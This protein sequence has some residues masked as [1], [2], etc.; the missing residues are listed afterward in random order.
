[1]LPLVDFYVMYKALSS[2]SMAIAC[3][4]EFLLVGEFL[5]QER[6][7]E[8]QEARA[9][10]AY[11]D[12]LYPVYKRQ[13]E[14]RLRLRYH[15]LSFQESFDLLSHDDAVAFLLDME[16]KMDHHRWRR[17]FQTEA[18]RRRRLDHHDMIREGSCVLQNHPHHHMLM[19]I[20]SQHFMLSLYM[21]LLQLR[22]MAKTLGEVLMFL[23]C[24]DINALLEGMDESDP[25]YSKLATYQWN[26]S[27][28]P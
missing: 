5:L 21:D 20:A 27:L 8:E 17:L 11:L 14:W 3:D 28:I 26:P 1:M 25:L 18:L 12:I 23:R 22:S 19:E 16:G 13:K 7:K 6:E 15:P 10:F 9:R 4:K 24:E 2:T